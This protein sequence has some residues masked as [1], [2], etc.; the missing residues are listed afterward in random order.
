MYPSWTDGKN[1]LD[2]LNSIRRTYL[3]QTSNS[4]SLVRLMKSSTSGLGLSDDYGNI[5]ANRLTLY[6]LHQKPGTLHWLDLWQP[7]WLYYT[8]RS[9]DR[10]PGSLVTWLIQPATSEQHHIDL[11]RKSIT[12]TPKQGRHWNGNRLHLP[13][14]FN[15][16]WPAIYNWLPTKL[17]QIQVRTL[18][19]TTAHVTHVE[20]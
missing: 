1:V 14:L 4:L 3:N 12:I 8:L 9:L 20:V 6:F 17:A 11:Q 16:K 2:D 7:W 19:F 10:A 5:Q 13:L 18:K 15:I